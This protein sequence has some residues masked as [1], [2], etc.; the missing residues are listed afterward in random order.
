MAGSW[1]EC[2]TDHQLHPCLAPRAGSGSSVCAGGPDRD[3]LMAA[4]VLPGC[5]TVP[6]PFAQ[7]RQFAP[8]PLLPA[9]LPAV[10][11]LPLLPF[12]SFCCMPPL[13]WGELL[14]FPAASSVLFAAP[15]LINTEPNVNESIHAR[16]KAHVH[17]CTYV[18]VCW[19][20]LGATCVASDRESAAGEQRCAAAAADAKHLRTPRTPRMLCTRVGERS[21]PAPQSDRSE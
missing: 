20:L 21:L 9:C 5:L 6:A 17:A 13:P 7:S 1:R 12:C 8:A 18:C 14:S 4:P 11:P 10:Y 16:G 19:V 3:A 15:L 2:L